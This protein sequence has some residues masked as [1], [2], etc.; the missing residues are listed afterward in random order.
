MSQKIVLVTWASSGIWKDIA[1]EFAREWM[2]VIINYSKSDS[3]AQEVKKIIEDNWWTAII[4]KADISKENEVKEM[5]NQINEKFWKLDYL[6]NNAWINVVQELEN[7]EL[8]DWNN[9]INVNLTGKFLCI[10]Y[11]I[12]L[13]KLSIDARIIN[14]AS[15]FGTK[16]WEE[17]IAYSCA[18]AGVIMLTQVS[19]LELAKYKIRVNTVSP[20]LTRTTLTERI[21]NEDEFQEYANN[22]PLGRV[23]KTSD[24]VNIVSFLLSE[25]STFINWENINVSGWIILK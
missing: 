18:E 9:I 15:R 7:Y 16:A 20:S 6:I 3:D 17:I 22:N 13:L 10:K 25:K 4:I 23:W 19:A 1:I 21:C 14:I 8:E 2:I 24:I 12:P 5:M 11:A